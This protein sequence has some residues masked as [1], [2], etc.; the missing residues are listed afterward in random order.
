M[1]GRDDD[2][3]FLVYIPKLQTIHQ[4]TDTAVDFQYGI[5]RRRRIRAMC[6]TGVVDIAEI[7]CVHLRTPVAWQVDPLQDLI[8]PRLVRDLSVVLLPK[9]RT[10][11]R[12]LGPGSR[13]E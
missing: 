13:K 6:V 2:I 4:P 8:D 3:Y 5:T 9:G 7:K 1:V 11:A 10:P 12:D